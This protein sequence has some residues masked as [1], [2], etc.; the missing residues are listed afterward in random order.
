MAHQQVLEQPW[1][2][3]VDRAHR[4]DD[5][6]L[7][8]QLEHDGDVAEL[9]VGID[10]HDRSV[11]P[12]G[13]HHR[14]VRRD[15]GLAGAA[16]GRE[17]GDD[18][19]QLATASPVATSVTADRRERLDDPG[20]ESVSCAVSTGAGRTS[21]MPDRSA[22]RN[23]SVDSSGAIRIAPTSGC[24]LIIFSAACS[25]VGPAQDGPSTATRGMPVSRSP[26]AS[27]LARGTAKSPSCIAN[28][29]RTAWSASTT[30]TAAPS[31]PAVRASSF[32][33]DV[34]SLWS[35]SSPRR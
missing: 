5:R 22:W 7:R 23:S 11:G 15:D 33:V 13:Q 14:E 19:A 32:E 18:L 9:E 6:V 16:L 21:R 28:R 35:S 27:M 12:P 34:P 20:T 10:E 8:R 25:P 1:V 31:P 4:V 26:S 17:H 29:L 2:E 3:P 30:A 24:S